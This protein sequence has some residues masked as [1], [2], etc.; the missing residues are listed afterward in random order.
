MDDIP[1]RSD[2]VA[3]GGVWRR[4]LGAVVIL[5]IAIGVTYWIG[6]GAMVLSDGKHYLAMIERSSGDVPLPWANRVL[7]P[8][9]IKGLGAPSRTGLLWSGL[10]GSWL[11]LVAM[12][13]LLRAMEHTP[14]VALLTTTLMCLS[15]PVAYYISAWGRIDPVAGAMVIAALWATHRARF[16]WAVLAISIGVLSKETC[17]LVIPVAA[18]QAWR[19]GGPQRLVNTL[20]LVVLPFVALACVWL[21]VT[22]AAGERDP[23]TAEG[24]GRYFSRVWHY[25]VDGFGL[26]PRIGRELL[27]SYGFFWTL[28]FLGFLLRPPWRG[29]CLYLIAVGFGLCV[30]AT[31]WAR[32]LGWS[33]AGIFI[34]MAW[35][36]TRAKPSRGVTLGYAALLVLAA[37]QCRLFFLSFKKLEH[38]TQIAWLAGTIG[39]F[40]AGSAVGVYLY[41]HADRPP[42]KQPRR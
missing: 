36:L 18:W 37:I 19:H 42:A 10:V 21:M 16:G 4:D 9:V 6:P 41:L 12:Y 31:D 38:S 25:N 20:A 39:V 26:V 11:A 30:V 7:V 35:L 1:A 29:P 8:A 22:P 15:Y 13:R 33:A 5:A 17:A 14:S 32:M 27:K 23:R 28:A 34:P 3:T 40:L 2:S 24:L